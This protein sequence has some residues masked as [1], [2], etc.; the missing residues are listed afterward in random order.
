MDDSCFRAGLTYSLVKMGGLMGSSMYLLQVWSIWARSNW[1]GSPP[2]AVGGIMGF[3]I[4]KYTFSRDN[5]IAFDLSYYAVDWWT[6]GTVTIFQY[7]A[8]PNGVMR[9][10]G[11]YMLGSGATF[12]YV[13][14]LLSSSTTSSTL[15]LLIC[16]Y[17]SSSFSFSLFMGG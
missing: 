3:I 4:G 6:T 15:L 9:T 13:L 16:I 11:K 8:G 1:R 14:L 7:G 12:G 2:L 10:L 5:T 17:Y